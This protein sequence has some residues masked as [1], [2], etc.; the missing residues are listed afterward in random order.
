MLSL[1]INDRDNSAW[2]RQVAA[3][4]ARRLIAGDTPAAWA[5]NTDSEIQFALDHL[6]LRSGDRVLDLGCGWGRHSLPLAAYG[7]RVVG[8]DLSRELL[9]LAR[10]YARRSSLPVQWIEAD[11]THLPLRGTFDAVVQFCGNLLTW[12]PD[13]D[14][15]IN[16]LWHV[17]NLL[18]PGGRL[19]LGSTDWQ[20]DLPGRTQ[21]YDEWRGGAAIYRQQYDQDRRIAQTQTVVFGPEHQRQEYRRQTW[22]PSHYDMESMFAQVGLTICGRYNTFESVSYQPHREGLIYVLA[23]EV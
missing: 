4:W 2:Y 8:L 19:M 17:A 22:W 21:H 3:G 5:E 7:L 15:A 6:R 13:H 20:A 11:V 9:A 18:R 1:T 12:F 10:Y 23:R 16:V 14:Q